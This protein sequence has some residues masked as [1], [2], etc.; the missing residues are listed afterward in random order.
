VALA[1]G[2]GLSREALTNYLQGDRVPRADKLAALA[3]LMAGGNEPAARR[4][5]LEIS[6][7]ATRRRYAVRWRGVK[8]IVWGK[9]EDEARRKFCRWAD[10]QGKTI[11]RV[12][13]TLAAKIEPR[14]LEGLEVV[15]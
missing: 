1:E 2:A 11:G 14:T 15:S 5:Y 9:D 12:S 8:A 13:V 6:G 3:L 4:I 7:M 10:E